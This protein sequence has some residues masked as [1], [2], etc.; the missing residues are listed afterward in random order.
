[1]SGAFLRDDLKGMFDCAEF[2]EAASYRPANGRPKAVRIIFDRPIED[3]GLGTGGVTG[4]KLALH[5]PVC[6]WPAEPLRG[7][8]IDV[9]IRGVL[10]SYA[11]LKARRDLSGDVW[12][13][14]LNT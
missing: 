7:D 6:D 4:T 8:W 9:K 2:A 10:T 3:M 14:E 12:V 13:V 5:L 1:M 11:V